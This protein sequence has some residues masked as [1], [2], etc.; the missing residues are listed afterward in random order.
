MLLARR[1]Q[2][3]KVGEG[4]MLLARRQQRRSIVSILPSTPLRTSIPT[5]ETPPS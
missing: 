2:W 1:Q 4:V 3:R 5:P